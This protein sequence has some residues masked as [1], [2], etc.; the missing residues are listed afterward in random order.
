MGGAIGEVHRAG[1]LSFCA[2]T[3]ARSPKR[4]LD[5]K[6]RAAATAR[7]YASGETP[8]ERPLNR[9]LYSLR[10]L[11][12][13]GSRSSSRGKQSAGETLLAPGDSVVSAREAC[14]NARS[15]QK[16]HAAAKISER[17]RIQLGRFW[18]MD[19]IYSKEFRGLQPPAT[20]YEI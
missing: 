11:T 18:R 1:T 2:G 5:G 6:A 17:T 10:R 16:S 15:Q 8:C 7:A 9:L 20:Q 13:S 19:F 14:A 12:Y 4:G 3:N